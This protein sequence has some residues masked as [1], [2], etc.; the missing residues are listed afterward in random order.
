MQTF[1][2]QTSQKIIDKR[3]MVTEP[4]FYKNNQHIF[5][6]LLN[7]LNKYKNK[8]KKILNS[9]SLLENNK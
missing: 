1:Y 9:N 4:N 3:S 5:H 6:S 8:N 7:E 2:K